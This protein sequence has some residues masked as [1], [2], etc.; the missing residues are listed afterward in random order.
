MD[1]I[2]FTFFSYNYDDVVDDDLDEV[3]DVDIVDDIFTMD[4]I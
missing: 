2:K 4:N 1:G 3:N